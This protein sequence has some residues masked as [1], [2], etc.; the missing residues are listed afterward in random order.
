VFVQQSKHITA[1]PANPEKV[2][3]SASVFLFSLSLGVFTPQSHAQAAPKAV[4][5]S[6][7]QD[8]AI[9]DDSTV[10][11]PSPHNQE[12]QPHPESVP[13]PVT[14]SAKTPVGAT[15]NAGGNDDGGQLEAS[16][17]NQPKAPDTGHPE[18]SGTGQPA[19]DQSAKPAE[20][21]ADDP[22]PAVPSTPAPAPK[23]PKGLEDAAVWMPDPILRDWMKRVVTQTHLSDAP[24]TDQN[25]GAF[26][27]QIKDLDE[28]QVSFVDT[29]PTPSKS[30]QIHN[31]KGLEQFTNVTNFIIK[32][33]N[34]IAPDVFYDQAT[35]KFVGES[36]IKTM[37]KLETLNWEFIGVVDGTALHHKQA[38]DNFDAQ[39]FLDWL[40]S[41][42]AAN[43]QNTSL[44]ELWLM[45]LGLRGNIPDFS[46]FKGLATVHLEN[47]QLSGTI[48]YYPT[49]NGPDTYTNAAGYFIQHHTFSVDRNNL[50]GGL[51]AGHF[52]GTLTIAGN[53]MTTG[54][55]ND[56]GFDYSGEQRVN[57]GTLTAAKE[58]PSFDLDRLINHFPWHIQGHDLGDEPVPVQL[59][60]GTTDPEKVDGNGIPLTYYI[61]KLDDPKNSG[62]LAPRPNTDEDA[63][64]DNLFSITH[65]RDGR[66]ILTV[67]P[68]TPSG[69]Y[70]LT[71]TVIPNLNPDF[72]AVPY[73]HLDNR[74]A[75]VTPP[76]PNPE[77]TPKPQPNPEPTPA[78][79]P[80][81][82]PTPEPTPK[83]QPTPAPQP[84]P[85][86]RPVPKPTS[87]PMQ[88]PMAT[89]QRR[90]VTPKHPGVTQPNGRRA[91]DNANAHVQVAATGSTKNALPQTNDQNNWLA[92]ILGGGLLIGLLGLIVRKRY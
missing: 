89:A 20:P 52:D 23:V 76:N 80:T 55:T 54:L 59:I 27:D 50:T 42:D 77:P 30:E 33:M 36:P 85:K 24:I 22:T 61:Y 90:P 21:D 2:W 41:P 86:P 16:N 6:Q 83:P 46:R 9:T 58:N 45:G 35:G 31:L 17:S 72:Y 68:T 40:I 57:L 5:T 91:Q 13:K 73:F 92:T 43:P 51:P 82:Q 64:V 81:P 12:P 49:L 37:T 69:D 25:L 15:G 19:S 74:L 66:T 4:A 65:D 75:P 3:I 88:K 8:H 47:N 53:Q 26:V 56:S 32:D 34:N 79:Q 67:K 87:K 28:E 70:W 14:S 44:N 7:P 62:L 38:D 78:P 1:R 10:P 71:T 18:V 48:V 84:A 39:K 63:N 60:A 11:L 29:D